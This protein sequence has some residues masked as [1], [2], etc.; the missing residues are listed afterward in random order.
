MPS[1]KS[2]SLRDEFDAIKA[3]ITLL[4]KEG[5]STRMADQVNFGLRRSSS[6]I[7]IAICLEWTHQM[8]SKNSDI[9]PSQTARMR[10]GRSQSKTTTQV[11]RGIR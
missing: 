10:P 1:V 7:P 6:E 11:R 4:Q 3:D 9:P 8:T 2:T 5:Q